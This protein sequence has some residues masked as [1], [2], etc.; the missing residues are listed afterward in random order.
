[1]LL[2]FRDW[3]NLEKSK[4]IKAFRC[5]EYDDCIA[6]ARAS[7]I[8]SNKRKGNSGK[9]AHRADAILHALEL[10]RCHLTNGNEKLSSR[11]NNI[12]VSCN[13]ED[14]L[15]QQKMMFKNRR[16]FSF[17]SKKSGKPKEICSQE[18]SHSVTSFERPEQPLDSTIQ[19]KRLK[20][21]NDS[22]DDGDEGIRRMKD[23]QDLD[24]GMV[25]TGKPNM[26]ANMKE[27]RAKD[28]SGRASRNESAFAKTISSISLRNSFKHSYTQLFHAYQNLKRKNRRRRR[29]RLTKIWVGSDKVDVPLIYQDSINTED[30]T[31]Y[32]ITMKRLNDLKSSSKKTKFSLTNNCNLNC[33]ESLYARTSLHVKEKNGIAIYDFNPASVLRDEAD[34]LS[35]GLVNVP[36][37]IG[38]RNVEGMI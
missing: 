21:P 26:R 35:N 17:T 4:R 16:D 31:S 27:S 24:L 36:I 29:R 14:L 3:Y 38:E 9:Y 7:V 19:K 1:M 6:R 33:S 5:G 12:K 15:K 22:E 25:T 8:R 32:G 10:E 23:L 18:L 2:I 20:N 11:K 34:S 13:A 30:L 28:P 37:L